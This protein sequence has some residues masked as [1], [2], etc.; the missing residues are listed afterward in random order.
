MLK[1]QIEHQEDL[2]LKS[3]DRFSFA[4]RG[5][6][7]RKE[8]SF[9]QFGEKSFIPEEEVIPSVQNIDLNLYPI[10]CLLETSEKLNSKDNVVADVVNQLK[11]L[12]SLTINVTG[13]LQLYKV[14]NC[15]ELI[16]HLR[17]H[18]QI[19]LQLVIDKEFFSQLLSKIKG[20]KRKDINNFKN[21]LMAFTSYLQQ[22]DYSEDPL[23]ESGIGGAST[24]VQIQGRISLNDHLQRF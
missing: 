17:S 9:M 14:V 24:F 12:T 23:E 15:F 21:E 18:F 19:D 4:S 16:K 6:I 11:M 5:S 1:P 3:L 22:F 20:T 7:F 10:L 8:A 13:E 2:N